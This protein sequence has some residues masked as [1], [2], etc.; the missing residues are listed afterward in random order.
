MPRSFLVKTKQQQ[1]QQQQQRDDVT[2]DDV[3][4]RHVVDDV[5]VSRRRLSQPPPYDTQP[6]FNRIAGQSVE[7]WL[8]RPFAVSP[9][10]RF[11]PWL[12]RSRTWYHCDTTT[13][14]LPTTFFSFFSNVFYFDY[15]YTKKDNCTTAL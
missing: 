7:L 10:R 4:G 14:T 6:T 15:V 5:S 12:V 9:H 11:A 1:Q 3:I 13:E 8:I 2:T